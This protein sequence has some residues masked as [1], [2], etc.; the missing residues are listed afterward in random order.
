MPFA[1]VL[2]G[3]PKTPID[4]AKVTGVGWAFSIAPST[5]SDAPP[6]VADLTIDDVRFY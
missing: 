3:F 5:D 2:A 4:Q 6:C 1:G